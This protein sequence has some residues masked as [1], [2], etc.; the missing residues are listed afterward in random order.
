I[1][2]TV[3]YSLIAARIF[4]DIEWFRCS[5]SQ[6]ESEG[7]CP[8]G[9]LFTP[10]PMIELF[11]NYIPTILVPYL[12]NIYITRMQIH[13]VIFALFSSIIAPFG[14]FFASAMKRAYEKKDF[15]QI[16]PG[17][18]GATD[19]F[20]CQFIIGLFTFVYYTTW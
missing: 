1:I 18:G 7:G 14:G 8:P 4:G 2:I 6:L 9:H 12:K 13:S 3:I 19:R 20:D 11:K 15:D 10:L 16:F 5:S 17:H